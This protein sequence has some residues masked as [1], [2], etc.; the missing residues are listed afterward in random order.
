MTISTAFRAL[1]KQG[2][3]AR[4]RFM[5]CQGCALHKLFQE[6][7]AAEKKP[8]GYVFFHKQNAE[9]LDADGHVYLAFG[10][11]GRKNRGRTAADMGKLI[12]AACEAAGCPVD[13]S[14]DADTRI[15]VWRDKNAR[16][17]HAARR[18]GATID[19]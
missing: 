6:Y 1:R 14:G 5:C 10:V 13:W 12:V 2:I 4:Q 8:V 16:R 3:V 17:I 18:L 7:N 19:G 15:L 9:R 11:F